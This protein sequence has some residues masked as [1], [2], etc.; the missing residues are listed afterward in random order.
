MKKSLSRRQFLQRSALATAG[1]LFIP[2]FLK[3]LT[4]PE[5]TTPGDRKL[6][7][8]QLGGGNDGLNAIVPYGDDAYYQSRPRIGI[9]TSKVLKINDYLGFHPA[10]APLREM[11]DDGELALVNGVGYPDPN[12]SH[13]RSMDIWQT[14]SGSREY[15]ETGWLGRYLDLS[16]ATRESGISALEISQQLSLAMKG[17]HARGLAVSDPKRFYRT[18]AS[19]RFKR[20]EQAGVHDHD[21]AQA[22]YLY[23]TLAT[24]IAS[25]EEIHAQTESVTPGNEYAGNRLGRQL[26]TV[27]QMIRSGLETQVYYVATSGF[28]THVNQI[29]AHQR[30]L[31]Q[32][33]GS[34]A[35][36][37]KEMKKEGQWNNVLVMVFSEFGRRVAEN[38]SAGTDHGTAGNVY[39]LG[40]NLRQPGLYNS[41]PSLTDLDQGDLKYSVDFRRIYGEVLERWLG[42]SSKQVLNQ[43]FDPL[44]IL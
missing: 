3:A 22:S 12:R 40:G 8:V 43:S 23:Q 29:N 6:I 42:S 33:A 17:E 28:D 4:R 15:L 44:G 37:R 36:F 25:A 24:G 13:F 39:L 19:P 38:A 21:H 5:A 41:I 9:P 26:R 20:I 35:A 1:S 7:V 34:L 14:G 11:Y 18:T 27:G 31:E 32:V 10:L 30:L 2:R 16:P